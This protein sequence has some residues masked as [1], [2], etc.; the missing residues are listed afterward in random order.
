MKKTWTFAYAKRRFPMAGDIRACN[1]TGALNAVE[2]RT[3]RDRHWFK[4]YLDSLKKSPMPTSRDACSGFDAAR[5]LVKAVGRRTARRWIGRCARETRKWVK[6][7]NDAVE[8]TATTTR[9]K[10]QRQ[11]ALDAG[12][13]GL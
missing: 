2:L 1:L 12:W 10:A 11:R 3:E 8:S 5:R 7:M 4:A 6:R 13:S 9:T